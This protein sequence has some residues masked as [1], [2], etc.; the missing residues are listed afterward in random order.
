[1]AKN[2]LI[3]A[4]C[5][6]IFLSACSSCPEPQS[7]DQIPAARKLTL[8]GR[9]MLAWNI[10]HDK[11]F[12]KLEHFQD[13]LDLEE[14]D[15]ASFERRGRYI[16]YYYYPEQP[17]FPECFLLFSLIKIDVEDFF[18]VDQETLQPGDCGY[19]Y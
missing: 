1:M 14:W 8:S 17:G 3:F 11:V 5:F 19:W 15:I 9:Q 13:R 6:L 4:L 7:L 12:T 2:S 16:F 18:C 10:H